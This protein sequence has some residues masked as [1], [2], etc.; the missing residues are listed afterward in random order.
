MFPNFILLALAVVDT[1]HMLEKDSITLTLNKDLK[2]IDR[3]QELPQ[4][5]NEGNGTDGRQMNYYP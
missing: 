2:L 3:H 5:L 1:V 4:M